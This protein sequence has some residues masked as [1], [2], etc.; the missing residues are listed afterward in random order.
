M[1]SWERVKAV[2]EQKSFDR[3]P[4]YGWLQA[5][6]D[7]QITAAFGSVADFEDQYE[8]DYAHLF[9]CPTRCRREDLQAVRDSNDG[10]VEPSALLD[11]QLADVNEASAYDNLREGIEH[12]KVQRERFVYVQP[13]GSFER[14]NSQFGIENHLMYL[15]LYERELHEVYRRQAAWNRQ[16]AMNCLDLGIDMIHVSDDWGAQAGLM[17]SPDTWKSLTIEELTFAFDLIHKT[18]NGK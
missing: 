8:F 12:H 2:I 6:L 18:V 11:L 5:N 16:F 1:K 9:G 3:I 4:V 17:F 13:P 10:V 15:A 7:E 14:L